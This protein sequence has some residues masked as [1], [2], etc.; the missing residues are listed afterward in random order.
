MDAA[1]KATVQAEFR[2]H[3]TDT[4]SSQVQIALLSARI[5]DL[6][7]HLGTHKKDHSSRRG[8]IAM[9]N[10]RRRLLSY[11]KRGNPSLYRDMIQ[12]LGLRR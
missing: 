6:T 1:T 2:Q 12:R 7:E 9:V 10:R 8:L 4:G 5:K 3:E 11:V